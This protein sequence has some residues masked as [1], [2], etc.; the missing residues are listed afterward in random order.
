[1][2]RW[3]E[4]SLLYQAMRHLRRSHPSLGRQEPLVFHRPIIRISR[5]LNRHDLT[6][7]LGKCG[8]KVFGEQCICFHR[9]RWQGSNFL[10]QASFFLDSILQCDELQPLHRDS[11]NIPRSSARD[12]LAVE[13]YC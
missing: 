13:F 9:Y 7:L 8:E 10:G 11:S 5:G 3:E 2:Y 1:M 12:L 4:L 6:Y